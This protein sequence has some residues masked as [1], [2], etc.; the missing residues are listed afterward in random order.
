[1]PPRWSGAGPIAATPWVDSGQVSTE[2]QSV[3]P[4]ST[5]GHLQ[6]DKLQSRTGRDAAVQLHDRAR[7]SCGPIRC[8]A[9]THVSEHR[10]GWLVPG[11]E[12]GCGHDDQGGD[13]RTRRS[14]VRVDHRR[15]IRRRTRR[16]AEDVLAARLYARQGRPDPHRFEGQDHHRPALPERELAACRRQTAPAA[17]TATTS[18]TT[19]PRCR[20]T[21]ARCWCSSAPTTPGTATIRSTARA[22]RCR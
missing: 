6:L 9:S 5:M 10:E 4:R 18:T 3:W 21:T 11:R 1:M 15:E 2:L 8:A 20:P 13:R 17:R 14:R 22:A 19:S 16:P 12:P 7:A